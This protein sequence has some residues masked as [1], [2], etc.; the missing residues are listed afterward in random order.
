[1]LEKV[2]MQAHLYPNFFKMS[3]KTFTLEL[4]NGS[5]LK[6]ETGRMAQQTNGSAV[7]SIGDTVI[8]ATACMSRKPMDVDFLPLTVSYQEKLYASGLIA[9]SKV[10]KREGRP[11]DEK[12]LCARVIDRTLRPLFPKGFSHNL[13]TMLTILSYDNVNE[14]DV[15]AGTAASVAF[16]ISDAPFEGPVAMVRV[17]MIDGKFVL[18]PTVKERE[19]SK[20]DLIVSATEKNVVMIECKA[21]EVTEAEMLAAIDFGS[22]EGKKICQ[23]ISKIQAEIGREKV[24]FTKHEIDSRVKPLVEEKYLKVITE[25]IFDENLDKLARF[26]KFDDLKEEATEMIGAVLNKDAEEGTAVPS[27]DIAATFDKVMKGVIRSSILDHQKRIKGRKVNQIRPLTCEVDILPRPHG[28]ALFTRGETQ[29]LTITTLAGP[30]QK[31]VRTG[32]E[33]EKKVRY[34]HHYNFPPF[35]VG[36][37]SNRLATGNREIGHG[38]LAEKALLCVL[39][40]EKDF[41]YTIRT[42]TEILSSN[43]SSSMASV[44]GSTLSLMAAG[45][46][47]KAPVAGIA[48]GLMTDEASGKYQILTDLQD[49]EDFGGD[50]DFK[51]AGTKM[52]ITAIQMDIKLKGIPMEIFKEALEQARVGRLQIMDAMLAAI[53]EARKTLSPYAPRMEVVQIHKDKIR[54]LIGKG[55]E[56]INKI[57]DLT[58]VAIDINDDGLVS[59]TCGP[60]G[61]ME[62]ALRMIEM[63]T[64]MP[65]P[66][67]TY[68]GKVAKVA[69][70]G[71]FVTIMPGTDGL[72]H[73]SKMS[74]ERV[75]HPADVVREGDMVKVKLL[76][77]DNQ[78]RLQLSMV[79]AE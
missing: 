58:G 72:V 29:G 41:P 44:C 20:L 60:E 79:D 76:A 33:G 66:G 34:F 21:D 73:V 35:S 14:H 7:V 42:V 2:S 25:T 24:T 26:A 12:V 48:M 36:E 54:D 8:L 70:F 64:A 74:K 31:L 69:D 40:D 63:V 45:V 75:A 22:M 32:M 1:M 52:G 23:F 47:I 39:P 67:K 38:A 19:I 57:I 18:N 11:T 46:P 30:E 71:A 49:E 13:Q 62:E 6:V 16:A 3:Q 77:I 51:V 5:T 43:G 37:V 15:L 53:P 59:V 9:H 10:N 78:G 28:S 56:M 65:E 55:G 68:L 4:S 50:M 17:G 27:A 61:N